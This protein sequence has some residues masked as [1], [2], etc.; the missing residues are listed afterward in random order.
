MFDSTSARSVLVQF[1]LFFSATS[2]NNILDTRRKA[3]LFRDLRKRSRSR[4]GKLRRWEN[5]VYI[6]FK[7]TDEVTAV[8]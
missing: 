4:A 5:R 2:S 8:G 7:T 6:H 3:A 1:L